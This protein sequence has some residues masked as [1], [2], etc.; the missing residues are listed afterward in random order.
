MLLREMDRH[1]GVL[2]RLAKCFT[3]H[4]NADQLRQDALLAMACEQADALGER[5]VAGHS[6]NKRWRQRT[7]RR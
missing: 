1:T 5:R 4:R 2:A 7:P 3:N 6:R